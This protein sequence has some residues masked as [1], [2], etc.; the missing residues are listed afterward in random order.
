M[1]TKK[2]TWG[3][4]REISNEVYRI[5]NDNHPSLKYQGGALVCLIAGVDDSNIVGYHFIPGFKTVCRVDA[6]IAEF[7]GIDKKFLEIIEE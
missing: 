5:T 4:E 6:D 2:D 3:I 1:A 7:C